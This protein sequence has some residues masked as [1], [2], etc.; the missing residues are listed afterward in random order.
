MIYKITNKINGKVY[1]GAHKTRNPDDN[2]WGSGKYLRAAIAKHGV[3]NFTKEILHTF[4]NSND[5]FAKELEIVNEEFLINE[6]TY[7]LKVG[8]KGGW[9]YDRSKRKLSEEHKKKIS[10]AMKG[11]TPWIKGKTHNEK[12]KKRFSEIHSG[13]VVSEETRMKMSL[14]RKGKAPWNKGMTT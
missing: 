10:L 1:I 2:Y 4:D 8:G 3:E 11:K 5:M 6:N 9:H 13:K 14:A 7:N 12:T